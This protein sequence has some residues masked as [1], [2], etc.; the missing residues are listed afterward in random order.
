MGNR[1]LSANASNDWQTHCGGK[2]RTLA[3]IALCFLM[4]I[5]TAQAAAR[6]L[7]GTNCTPFP[8]N[9]WWQADISKLP[10]H[11]RNKAWMS[12]MQSSRN[13]WPD[14]G[15]S[16]GA[17]PGPYGMPIT[18]VSNTDPV[19]SVKFLYAAESD[20]VRYP[21]GPRTKVEGFNWTAPGD[22]HTITVNK[23]TC[24]L[25]ETWATEKL[26]NGW[27][28]GSGATWSLKSNALRPIYWTSADAA[29]LP[30]LPGLLR[31]DEVAA[32][33]IGHAIR[34]TIPVS[35]NT[36]LWP[37]RHKAG[38]VND[39]SFPPF[40]ARFRLKAN[41]RIPTGYGSDTKA[42]LNAMK[43]YGIVLADNGSPWF[44]QGAADT[45][46]Q[47]KMLNELKQIPASAFE[48]VDTS[49]LVVS[50]NSMAVKASR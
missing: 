4:S 3:V 31:Y 5:G 22:R 32:R 2:M 23:D 9:S 13:I 46:W 40:G 25:Y 14:F 35:D 38:A 19:A 1:Q 50:R 15:P 37:A 21:L 28:A 44:F 26:P 16:F 27:K 17:I 24:R 12:N 36:F 7:P 30:I 41:Y 10:V 33:D 45:R 48:A 6:K 18:I 29:G 8:A 47:L 20:K 11:T 39:R 49:S 43:K 42:V 34:F